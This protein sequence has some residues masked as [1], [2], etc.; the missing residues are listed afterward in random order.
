MIKSKGRKG[1][2]KNTKTER[3]LWGSTKAHPIVWPSNL[4]RAQGTK[5]VEKKGLPSRQA[6]VMDTER[7]DRLNSLPPCLFVGNLSGL[8]M[9][10]WKVKE[11]W[12]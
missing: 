1:E 9:S 10:S 2:Q 11:K 12:E 3:P 8:I 5:Q 7:M 4:L 6:S